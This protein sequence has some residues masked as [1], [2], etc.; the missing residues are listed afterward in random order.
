MRPFLLMP[1]FRQG[2]LSLRALGRMVRAARPELPGLFA[3]AMAD[4]LAGQGPLKPAD[5][6][7]VLADL[8]EEA[9]RFLKERLEPQERLPRLLTGHDLI[10]IFGL[11][12]G[13][14]FKQLLAALQ[15]AQWEGT[16]Q[17]RDEALRLV[18]RL[19]Q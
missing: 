16:V 17:T 19:L 14:Q 9:Y 2:E 6:E 5:S 13:P 18:R 1:T 10:K 4:S 7:A 12:P 11:K 15:E 8:A 3:L